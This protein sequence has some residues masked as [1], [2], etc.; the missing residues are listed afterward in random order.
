[1]PSGHYIRTKES[2]L[3]MSKSCMGLKKSKE[4][5]DKLRLRNKTLPVSKETRIKMGLAHKAEKCHFWKGGILFNKDYYR[6]KCLERVARK[7]NAEGSHS[8]G[9]WN[10]L[11]AQYNWTCPCCY[12]QEPSIKLTEDH[13]IP[14]SKGGS[15]NIE[16]IQPLCQVCNSKK[17]TKTIKY[18]I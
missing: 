12:E 18:Q 13:I 11:K 17:N 7:H 10:T 14:L 1:M 2:N 6:K 3:K 4:W 16:N 15:D 5:I 8:L 9:D